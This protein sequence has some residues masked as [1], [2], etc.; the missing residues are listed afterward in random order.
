MAPTTSTSLSDDQLQQL[1]QEVARADHRHDRRD[2]RPLRRQ[3]R[4]LRA[5]DRAAQPP[6]LAPRQDPLGRR[7]P[8]LSAQGADRP[9][10]PPRHD[11]PVQG[12]G[13]VLLGLRVRARHHGRR[14]RLHLDRL[15]RR[16]QGGDAPRDRRGRKGRRG[17][18]RRGAHR[19]GRLRG[20]S[21]RRRSPDP[22]RGRAQRQR[23]VD[24]AQRRRDLALLPA[25]AAEPE[26]VRGPLEDRGA[27]HPAA[28]WPRK[29][30]R[31]PRPRGEGGDQGLLGPG[32][33]LRG[34]RPRLRRR[35]RRPRRR[36]PA[37]GSERRP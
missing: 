32:A 6:R 23:D 24:L 31:A 1:A 28:A 3:P 30:I 20:A 34:A 4:D 27:A 17:D 16:P 13:P 19:R 18:R 2:R 35:R 8:G 22:D 12:A 15:R 33:V 36:R 5:G 11:P 9:P 37:P 10:R 21:Q 25:S 14:P 7:P 26:A 29:A